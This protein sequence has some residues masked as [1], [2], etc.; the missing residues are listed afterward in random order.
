MELV[1]LWVK[2]YK[3]IHNQGFNFS[4]RFECK[5]DD[6]KKE[7][8]IK[9]NDDYI[10]NFFGE[11]IN[12]T[13]IVGKNGSGKSTLLTFV[14]VFLTENKTIIDSKK[15]V[16]LVFYKENKFI[17][18]SIN[19]EYLLKFK[20]QDTKSMFYENDILLDNNP[21][22][23]IIFPIFDYSL[24][25]EKDGSGRRWEKV[26]NLKYKDKSSDIPLTG[27]K[28]TQIDNEIFKIFPTYP[29]KETNTLNFFK[30]DMDNL[31]KIIANHKTLGI[32]IFENFFIPVKIVLSVAKEHT[33]I[34]NTNLY[35]K[36]KVNQEF[37]ED[38]F[39]YF[40]EMDDFPRL[41]DI[42]LKQFYNKANKD[43]KIKNIKN[44]SAGYAHEIMEFKI[45]ELEEKE[46]KY[47][48]ELAQT[49]IFKVSLL[50]KDNKN[51]EDLSFGEQ[52]LLKILN[53]VYYLANRNE[54]I[55]FF[56]DE[57]DIGLHPEWQ[58][59]I[60]KYIIDILL[61]FPKKNFH[62]ILSSHS[63]FLLS[64]IPKENILFI[65][66]NL[67][68]KQ[69]FGA[70]I[71]TLLSDSFFMEDGLMGEFAKGKINEIKEFY[72]KAKLEKKTDEN[73]EFYNKHKEKFWQIQSII[74]EPFLQTVIK[75]YL[76]ELELLFSDDNTLIEKELADIEK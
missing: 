44:R 45:S 5:Y 9:E 3:N 14:K 61:E 43:F 27:D 35:E 66:G 42:S 58:K 34:K 57:I 24:T 12:V 73:V 64:D 17:P 8:T 47:L 11:N 38:T 40:N 13:A 60:F 46:I 71:H 31:R 62:L 76:D 4:P 55:I 65:N 37:S 50:D 63:P 51:L 75:N 53:I 54:N 25:Y 67:K 56:F 7:L 10:E 59:K 1:Y 22:N 26:G 39:L 28:V 41:K 19:T 30:E 18:L 23:N 74:G 21:L 32:K 69:T 33:R 36:I 70:N 2:D 48:L 20:N 68:Q 29:K 52:Q 6:V 15:K 49:E 16:V 72:E